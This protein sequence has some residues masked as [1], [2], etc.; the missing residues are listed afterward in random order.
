MAVGMCLCIA[1][2]MAGDVLMTVVM[3]LW[4][5]LGTDDSAVVLMCDH[6]GDVSKTVVMC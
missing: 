3:C 5:C 4:L 1:V 6:C 2:L